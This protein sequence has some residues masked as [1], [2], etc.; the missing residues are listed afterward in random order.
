MATFYTQLVDGQPN[1]A[2]TFNAALDQMEDAILARAGNLVRLT[3]WTTLTAD[4]PSISIP[5]V[6][7]NYGLQLMLSLRTDRA[8]NTDDS[9]RIRL[10]SDTA[11]TY[12][13]AYMKGGAA[14]T[15]SITTGFQIDFGAAAATSTSGLYAYS[16]VKFSRVS[17]AAARAGRFD[18]VHQ[19]TTGTSPN[20][21]E[22][23]TWYPTAVAISS[24]QIVPVNG[25]NF[26]AGS[27]Y[28]LYGTP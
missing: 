2:A 21:L 4:T 26:V 18:T 15:Y 6:A 11:S 5:V 13:T 27:Q 3:A 24:I 25:S 10:N 7:G 9:I 19:A 28:A 20:F 14:T 22:G 23:A 12:Q 1:R 17:D 16:I 8:A